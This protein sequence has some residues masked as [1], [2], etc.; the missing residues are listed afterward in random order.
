MEK[1]RKRDSFRKRCNAK[2]LLR[3]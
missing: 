2:L 1:I 3:C